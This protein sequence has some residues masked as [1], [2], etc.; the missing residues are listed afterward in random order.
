MK[1]PQ[2][3][4]RIFLSLLFLCSAAIPRLVAQEDLTAQQLEF[5]ENKVRP[6]LAQKCYKCHSASRKTP[7]GGLYLD[8]REGVLQ[9]GE[10][11]PALVPGD[12]ARS[13]LI[14]AVRYGN[15]DLQM[16]PKKK[17]SKA[18]IALLVKWVKMGAPDPRKG[19]KPVAVEVNFDMEARRREHWAWKAV[20]P[21]GAP[22]V[23]MAG[24][25][26]SDIDRHIL[27]G[28]EKAGLKPNPPASKRVMARRVFYALTG[29][30]PRPE[31][32]DAF[33]KEDSPAAFEGLVDR[34]L[35]SPHYG[36]HWGQHWLDLVRFSETKGHESDYPIPEAWRYRDYVIRGFN[37]DVPYD[38]WVI[39]HIAG[40]LLENP[41][42]DPQLKTNESIQGTG[43]WHFGEATHSPVDIRGE[44]ADRIHN[45]IDVFSKT[46]L[47]LSIGCAR[48][49]DHK[50]DAI[51][52]RDYYAMYGFIQSSGFQLADIQEP[53]KKK[54]L[55]S[56]LESAHQ[57]ARADLLAGFAGIKRA[58]FEKLPAYLTAA[59]EAI[60]LGP[61]DASRPDAAGNAA[62][63]VFENFENPG[64][65]GWTVKG[66][67]FGAGPRTQADL[68]DHQGDVGA[69]GK[70]FVNSHSYVTRGKVLAGDKFTGTM[71]S[72]PFRIDRRFINLLVGGGSHKGGTCVELVIDGKPVTSVTG[73]N[74]NRMV[75]R[76]IDASAWKGSTARI[77]ILDTVKDG[78]GNIGVD[79]IVFSDQQ[80]AG[81]PAAGENAGLLAR[82]NDVAAR[83]K[84]QG[85]VLQRVV[86]YVE[87][88]LKDPNDPLHAF[89]RISAAKDVPEAGGLRDSVVA[90]WKQAAAKHQ[91]ILDGRKVIKNIKNGERNYRK[92]ERAWSRETD[93]VVDYDNPGPEDWIVSGYRF[94]KRPLRGGQVLVGDEN[95]PVREFVERGRADADE[96]S[97]K[98]HGLLRTPTFEVVGDTLWYRVRGSCAA[99]LAVDS[100]RTVYGP[101]H[102]VV[103]KRIKGDSKTWRWHGHAVKDYLGHRIHLEFSNF[104]ANFAVSKVEFSAGTPP[105]L[106]PVNHVML[107]HVSGLGDLSP[108]ALGA[109]FA[110]QLR[111]SLDIVVEPGERKGLS[112]HARLLNWVLAR[113]DLL[114][115]GA[116]ADLRKA[117]AD[118]RVRKGEIEKNIPGTVRALALLDGSGENEPLHIR[119]N[120]DN[121]GGE[122][123]PRAILTALKTGGAGGKP[124]PR[125]S[126]RL[127]LARR[128]ASRENPLL[129]RVMVNRVW[130]HLFGRGIVASCDDFG[131]MGLPP[132]HPGLLDHL[133]FSFM[134]NGWSVKKLIRAILLSKT[135]GMS[136]TPQDRGNEVDP[137][138]KLLHRMP[139][140]RL[141]AESIRDKMLAVSGR[142]DRRLYGKG[143]MVHITEFMRG[144]RSPG[145][146]GP[147]DG[148]GRRSIYTEVRRNHLPSMLLA[149]DRPIP[150]MTM[151]KRVQS[152]SPAQA[153]I[154]LNDPFVH[155]QVDIWSKR[156]LAQKEKNDDELLFQAYLEAFG[157]TVRS[158]EA[159]AA[160]A[161]L[162]SQLKLYGQESRK[163]VWHD[164][165]HTLMNVKEFI[166]IN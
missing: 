28:I 90:K 70:G 125:G 69:R 143:V 71:L 6:L 60:R 110:K 163:K 21:P 97:R 64:Y 83:G 56:S 74:N 105:G 111:R 144:N 72:S 114:E 45:Q 126:G 79:H 15:S 24:W 148:N 92:V 164:L 139:I 20:T 43:F 123:V 42:V 101:L 23:G 153:L 5:F 133:A 16:P 9:G 4:P 57:K 44:E 138:N 115:P 155:Q 147:L 96:T 82:I 104:S 117:A 85:G 12:V 81:P 149:F 86:A 112:G 63:I 129:A 159:T 35:D 131:V 146:S 100:H 53:G 58:Q 122:V 136:S 142:L 165:L 29:L 2:L 17:L 75:P 98:F 121:R 102:G 80:A 19:R 116:S 87:A 162:A 11:G 32:V 39:E 140:L 46:F 65:I 38:R 41:R 51:S 108:A 134:E 76:S 48:C 135:Y 1:S 132:T 78:W 10:S 119:G 54:E 156:L 27:A 50:F 37:S 130:H 94:G 40:D 59:A 31:D 157:R 128:L 124:S 95:N 137:Q 66:L 33:L 109:A 55:A 8:T 14:E 34:L 120:H 73:S 77:R 150:F 91:G 158:D 99:F 166:F 88:A 118:Y 141:D 93:L 160:K 25:P 3:R 67:A 49:H 145:G 84:L 30:P 106:D 127:A 7:K 52:Q 151:G 18:E 113:E 89:A 36:E 13:R 161:F 62:E 103:K 154:L 152:N 22:E 68:P 107:S 47:G 26:G 61:L